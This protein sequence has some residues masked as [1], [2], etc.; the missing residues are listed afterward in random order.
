MPFPSEYQRATDHFC[1]FLTEVRDRCGYGS[2]HQAYTTVQGVFQ[3]FR[4]RL[5]LADAIR[6]A[7]ALPVG[8]RALFIADWDPDEERLPFID[9][10]QMNCEVSQLRSEHNFSTRTAIEEVATCLWLHVDREKL[11][12]VLAKLPTAAADFWSPV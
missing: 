7:G 1:A 3:V 9:H 11:E 5:S 4:C 6:F 2:S 8:M 10:A 12:A